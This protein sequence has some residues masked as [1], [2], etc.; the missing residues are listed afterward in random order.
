M[1]NFDVIR[2]T[3]NSRVYKMTVREEILRCPICPPNKGCN[4]ARKNIDNSWK[5]H[6]DN[7]WREK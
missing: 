7:Q 3:S 5:E 4:R 6:R 1:K 2:N